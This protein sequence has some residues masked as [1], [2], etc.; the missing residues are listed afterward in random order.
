MSEP[1]YKKVRKANLRKNLM[2]FLLQNLLPDYIDYEQL[3]TLK[4]YVRNET[5]D[6]GEYG[7][8]CD[9]YNLGGWF[10]DKM[11]DCNFDLEEF[12]SEYAKEIK[13]RAEE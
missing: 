3:E 6:A 13:W 5:E 9:Y 1:G 11:Y 7:A 12:Y 2:N 8:F 4:Q 10:K